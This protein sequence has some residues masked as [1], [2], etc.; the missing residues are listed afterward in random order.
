MIRMRFIT[1]ALILLFASNHLSAQ[2]KQGNIVQY[3]GKEKVEQITEGDVI[4]I[5]REGLVLAGQRFSMGS[6]A[7]SVNPLFAQVLQEGTGSIAEGNTAFTDLMGNESSWEKISVDDKNEFENRSLRRTGSLY[8]TYDSDVEKVVLLEASGHTDILINGYPYEGDHYDF[9]YS[10]V[11]VLLKQGKNEFI[12]SGGRFPRMRARLLDP[13]TPVQLTTRDMTLPDIILEEKGPFPG[14]IR[15]INAGEKWFKGGMI[16]CDTDGQVSE[17]NVPAISPLHVRKV[18]FHVPAP[19]TIP[20]EDKTTALVSLIDKSG[21]TVS[22]DTIE[23]NIKSKYKHHKRTFFSDIDGSVQYY[24]IAPSSDPDI[25]NPAM[26]LSVHGASVEAVNQANAYKHK[27]WGHLVAP[28]NRRPYGYAWEDWGR[29]DA[30][31]VLNHAENLLG[32]D[33]QRTYLTG[34][35]MGGHGTWQ[36]GATYPDRFAAIAPCAGYPDLQRYSRSYLERLQNMSDEQA[37]RWGIDRE[38]MIAALEKAELKDESLIMLDSLMR[39]SGN[40]GRTLKLKRNYLHHGVFILHGEKDNVVPTENA[41]RMRAE[42]GGFHNDFTY[43]EYPDGTHWYGN[44]SVDWPPIF[45]FFKARSIPEAK[46]IKKYEFYTASPGVSSGSHFIHIHQQQVPLEISSF[47]YNR[48]NRQG[49]KRLTTDNIHVMSIDLEAM[50]QGADTLMVDGQEFIFSAD[51]K[52]VFLKEQDGKWVVSQKPSPKEKG[53]HR[54]G[55]FKDA[56]N[57]HVVLVFATKGNDSENAWYYNRARFDAQTFG[58]LGNG[59]FEIVKDT[60]FKPSKFKDR[61]VVLYGNKDNNAAWNK[62]LKKCPVQVSDNEIRMGD[63]NLTGTQWGSFFIYPRPDSDAASVGVVT[64]TGE[65]GMKA[66]FANDYLGRDAFPDLIIFDAAMMADGISGL[67]CAGFF[68][69]DW[70]VENGDFQWNSK[71]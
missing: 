12:L 6:G 50:S 23:L 47:N 4:H 65:E 52:K 22:V 34:H 39:R 30:M 41:R 59:S 58:Y 7:V 17:Y 20:D 64:A 31:E 3:F 25:E 16:R 28:T 13:D 40:P 66:A 10:L 60:D 53:P 44:H 5:F 19:E 55:G 11:P 57:N 48:D 51:D 43:Y 32:T 24:S 15:V 37:E 67:E 46:D 14:A 38:K 18:P 27:E 26:F 61:N 8:L 69:N 9:G 21:K 2:E 63:K 45:D 70:S 36:I 33:R 42:L 35:S 54:N 29:I 56:F 62:L 68:G 49:E 71:Q 1:F